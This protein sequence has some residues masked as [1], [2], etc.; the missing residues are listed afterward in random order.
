MVSLVLERVNVALAGVMILVYPRQCGVRRCSL[1]MWL[2]KRRLRMFLSQSFSA[3]RT[4][5]LVRMG[6]TVSDFFDIGRRPESHTCFCSRL[7]WTIVQNIYFR[8]TSNPLASPPQHGTFPPLLQSQAHPNNMAGGIKTVQPR[9]FLQVVM[10]MS[11]KHDLTDAQFPGSN[12][13]QYLSPTRPHG[14]QI[15]YLQ[16]CP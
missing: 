12:D 7:M 3:N 2:T 14:A 1:S 8:L 6:T 9:Y 5:F 10:H 16:I 15:F 4:I 13:G 11:N